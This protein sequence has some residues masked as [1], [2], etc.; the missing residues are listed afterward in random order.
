MPRIE[1]TDLPKNPAASHGSDGW[2]ALL[3]DS[4]FDSPEIV[5]DTTPVISGDLADIYRGSLNGSEVAVKVTRN[6]GD[7]DLV[8]HEAGILAGLYPD[9]TADEKFYRYLP[10]LIASIVWEGKRV[11]IFPWYDGFVSLEDVRR[12]YPEGLDFRDMVWMFKRLLVGIGFAH[13]KDIVHGAI[14]PPH[15]MIFPPNHG[16]KIVDWSYAVSNASLKNSRVGAMSRTFRPF[17]APEI[18]DRQPPTPATDIYMA[19][20]CAVALI[21]GDVTT[22]VM[23][24]AVPPEVQGFLRR[25]IREQ[26]GL[27]PQNAWD[28]HDEFAHLLQSLV[29]PPTFRPFRMPP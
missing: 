24:D 28:L 13:T 1:L 9:G 2:S 16:A 5:F 10:R 14:L 11:N 15:V 26:P 8:E 6:V 21:G 22:L 20:K 18:L 12:A 23:P 3:D 7:N 19:A 27:R 25:C 17:Y 29:G 4:P